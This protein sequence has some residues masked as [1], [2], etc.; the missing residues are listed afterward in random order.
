MLTDKSARDLVTGCW[1]Y[2]K[3]NEDLPIRPSPMIPTVLPERP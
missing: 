1:S 2:V 3:V